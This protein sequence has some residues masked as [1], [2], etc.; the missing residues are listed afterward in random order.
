MSEEK[1]TVELT[2]AISVANKV[3][4]LLGRR[5]RNPSE[6]YLASKF[7]TIY[8]ETAYNLRLLP[9]EEEELR[10]FVKDKLKEIDGSEKK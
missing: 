5:T 9:S 8:F 6:A 7:V 1:T 3:M 2:K 4:K 10:S